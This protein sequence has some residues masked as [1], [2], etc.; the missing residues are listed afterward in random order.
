MLLLAIA[1]AHTKQHRERALAS[2]SAENIAA[3]ARAHTKQHRERV[4]ASRS[5]ENVCLL[6]SEK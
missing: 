6:S 2:R 5:A 1:C 3:I 4:L